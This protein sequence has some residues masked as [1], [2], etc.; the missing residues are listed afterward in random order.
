MVGEV[1]AVPEGSPLRPGDTVTHLQGWRDHAVVDAAACTPVGDV[2]PDPVAHL[3][4]GSSAYGALTRL[5]GVRA[6]DTVLV[7][8]AA[9]AVGTLAG[10]IARLLGAG[11]VIGTTRSPGKA[12][13]LVSELGYD[14]VL[15]SG[16]E[17]PSPSSSPRPHPGA[18]T[19]CWTLSAASS[20][21][22]PSARPGR[23]P[24]SPWSGRC[25][26]SCRRGARAAVRPP[27]STRSASSSR[28]LA[29][30]LQR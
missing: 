7:T 18:S 12:G 24:A 21:R 2:L 16:S 8:G 15:L 23:V 26:A 17:P 14:A 13:R 30:R 10:R 22:R 20:S 1:V 25:P 27:R 28:A 9:G 11:R 3:A 19:S 29:A 5:A 4:Q 6:G